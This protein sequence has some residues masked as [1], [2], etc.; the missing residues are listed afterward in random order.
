MVS[1]NPLIKMGLSPRKTEETQAREGASDPRLGPQARATSGQM[2]TSI[3]CHSSREPNTVCGR[4]ESH[5]S[6]PLRQQGQCGQSPGLSW[7]VRSRRRQW[8]TVL[9][10]SS[11]CPDPNQS[12][13]H[14]S[15][16]P[17]FFLISSC[18]DFISALLKKKGKQKYQVTFNYDRQARSSPT[19]SPFTSSRRG[20]TSCS[21]PRVGMTVSTRPY[22]PLDQQG[23]C[24]ARLRGYSD[25]QSVIFH[26]LTL[27]E[28]NGDHLLP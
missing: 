24:R 9:W 15:F 6:P 7:Q 28:H 2:D 25:G 13:K 11:S 27:T 21:S 19:P 22:L 17:Y 16:L 3:Y 14:R 5:R 23:D 20:Y 4:G 10:K 1:A 18:L 12:E 26:K 8:R